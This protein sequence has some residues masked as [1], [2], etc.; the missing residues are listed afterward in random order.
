MSW[1]FHVMGS[2]HVWPGFNGG[3]EQI[4]IWFLIEFPVHKL[5]KILNLSFLMS[6][7]VNINT[8]I[9]WIGKGNWG[10]EKFVL[11]LSSQNLSDFNSIVIK[12]QGLLLGNEKN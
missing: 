4:Q 12:K 3:T 7:Y 11:R 5:I 6:F 1:I 10:Q 8:E 2:D 9:T